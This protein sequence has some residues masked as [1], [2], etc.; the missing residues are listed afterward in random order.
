MDSTVTAISIIIP[1]RNRKH[2]TDAILSQLEAQMA[3]VPDSD[4]ISVA[5]VDDGSTDGT[6]DRVRDRFSFVHLLQ[7]D[8]SLWWTGAIVKGMKYAIETLESD[9]CVWL[10]DDIC[11]ADNWL[12]NLIKMCNK[13]FARKT[14]IGGIV[15]HEDY[16]NWIVFGGT[17]W[18][19][20][21]DGVEEHPVRSLDYFGDRDS[22]DVDDIN[23]NIAVIPRAVIDTIGYPNVDRFPH[24]GGDYEFVRRVT[25][26]GY[27]VMLTRRLQ[28]T[29][30]YA[31]ADLIRY[32]P[33]HL[34]WSLNRNLKKRLEIIQGLTNLKYHYNVWH[35]VNIIHW[36]YRIISPWKY[37]IYYLQQLLNLLRIDF[38]LTAKLATEVKMYCKKQNAP[39]EAIE[40][41]L[42]Q[43]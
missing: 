34:Q 33:P 37:R 3:D 26:A 5:V 30:Q 16:P 18:Q 32:M 1:V 23:G 22:I 43:I 7:G 35:I 31:I 25:K 28:A 17:R 15:C 38:L 12:D 9:F 29:T 21:P 41:I 40:Q 24:Y 14:V 19:T 6:P 13:P 20:I 42:Q 27:N 10:N 11:I 4:R 2:C 8:G 39:P 36:E